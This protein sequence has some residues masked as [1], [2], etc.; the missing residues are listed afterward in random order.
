MQVINCKAQ[1]TED[2]IELKDRIQSR[3]KLDRV[4]ILKVCTTIQVR[5]ILM[6]LKLGRRQRL[7][8]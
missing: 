6:L 8:L 4:D 5:K 2:V 7:F 3:V 1:C